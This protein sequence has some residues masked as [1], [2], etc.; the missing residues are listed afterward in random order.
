LRSGERSGAVH[1]GND[2]K[3]EPRTEPD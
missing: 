2:S 3:G 1:L